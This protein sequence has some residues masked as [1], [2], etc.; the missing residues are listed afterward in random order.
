M[1]TSQKATT[2]NN[3]IKRGFTLIEMGVVIF[4]IALFAAMVVPALA[5]WRAGQSYRDFPGKLLRF[6]AKAKL[7]AIDQKQSRTIGYD[8]TTDEFRMYWT[9]P[10]TQVDQEGGRLAI[11]PEMQLGRVEMNGN[12]SAIQ[13][14]KVTF[15][16]DGTAADAGVEVRNQD[17]YVTLIIDHLGNIKETTQPLP[18][19]SDIR[20][21]AGENETRSQ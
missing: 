2:A 14:W 17:Q 6:V 21:S 7:D 12:D 3:N 10:Q 11:P 4:L 9:D 1:P 20:W 13:D 16:Q 8:A 15:Y 19:Q 5:H 18:E